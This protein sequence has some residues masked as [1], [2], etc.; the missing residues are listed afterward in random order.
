MHCIIINITPIY[1]ITQHPY[2]QKNIFLLLSHK[3]NNNSLFDIYVKYLTS[4]NT[5]ISVEWATI[6]NKD[7]YIYIYIYI[8]LNTYILYDKTANYSRRYIDWI[9]KMD[10]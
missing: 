10:S 5:H 7:I 4:Y 2:W 8:Y 6:V 9:P 3:Q 1:Y